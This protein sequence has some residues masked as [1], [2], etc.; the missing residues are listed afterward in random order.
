M[1]SPRDDQSRAKIVSGKLSQFGLLT[2][3]EQRLV[4]KN[5]VKK[6]H[7]LV[8]AIP[9]SKRSGVSFCMS[10]TDGTTIYNSNL[11]DGPIYVGTYH[12]NKKAMDKFESQSYLHEVRNPTEIERVI[13]VIDPPSDP[14][15]KK[16]LQHYDSFKKDL[17]RVLQDEETPLLVNP[18]DLHD[19]YSTSVTGGL[20]HRDMREWAFTTQLHHKKITPPEAKEEITFTLLSSA[21]FDQEQLVKDHL[22]KIIQHILKDHPT[23]P[24][25]EPRRFEQHVS[26][27]LTKELDPDIAFKFSLSRKNHG[28]FSVLFNGNGRYG[29]MLAQ[30][31]AQQFEHLLQEEISYHI[32]Q[33]SFHNT[34]EIYDEILRTI[35]NL[36]ADDIYLSQWQKNT[37][38]GGGTRIE[39]NHKQRKLP[40]HIAQM[41]KQLQLHPGERKKS[42]LKILTNIQSI[43]ED[44][45]L[46]SSVKTL[47]FFDRQSLEKLKSQPSHKVLYRLLAQTL[48]EMRHDPLHCLIKLR[49]GLADY[50]DVFQA[51]ETPQKKLGRNN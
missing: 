21:K 29:D 31:C 19:S 16:V 8:D 3:E 33:K 35:K 9:E 11:G 39:V 34:D 28:S 26:M 40:E 6:L 38:I 46:P 12:L 4:Q 50:Q 32:L 49:S 14:K 42:V 51:E 37:G 41:E 20:G 24:Q 25:D 47:G 27:Y 13:K 45:H 2:P 30:K 1:S 48:G 22:Q 17:K 44:A 43:A 18:F 10:I 7:A 23:L 15:K 5:V 36:L